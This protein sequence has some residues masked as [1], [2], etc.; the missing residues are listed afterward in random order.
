VTIVPDAPPKEN[1]QERLTAYEKQHGSWLNLREGGIAMGWHTDGRLDKGTRLSGAAIQQAYASRDTLWGAGIMVSLL[2]NAANAFATLFLQGFKLV[3]GDISKRG[4]GFM[5]SHSSHQ[6]G[7]DADIAYI[8]Y[9]KF[10]LVLRGNSTMVSDFDFQK[11][12]G[13][14]RMLYG[15]N[16]VQDGRRHSVLNRVFMNPAIKRAFCDW[17]KKEGILQNPDDSDIMR[18]IRPTSGHNKHFHV[19]LRC[20]PYYPTCRNQVEPP[21]GHG[22]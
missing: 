14:L 1:F 10:H 5:P 8:G 6:I 7:L 11:N 20:S 15:Q 22:C 16:I 21:T 17:A 12:W 18:R 9:D 2:E 19:R 3:V 13:F 4:G